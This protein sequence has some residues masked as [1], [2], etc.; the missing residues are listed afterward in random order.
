MVIAIG[1]RSPQLV[2]T[3]AGIIAGNP[4]HFHVQLAHGGMADSGSDHLL[5]V[6]V[7]ILHQACLACHRREDPASVQEAEIMSVPSSPDRSP[8]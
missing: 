4:E 6:N 3:A 8:L 2:S 7:P 5:D 1:R